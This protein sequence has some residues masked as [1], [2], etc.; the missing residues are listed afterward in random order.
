MTSA[1]FRNR[2][3]ALILGAAA[4]VALLSLAALV[5]LRSTGAPP[6]QADEQSAKGAV[7]PRSA[8]TAEARP[9][10]GAT[11]EAA[12]ASP[13]CASCGTVE[14]VRTLEVRGEPTG[15]QE[16]EQHLSRHVVYRVTVR[17]EDGSYRTLSQ[18]T[19]PAIAVGAKVR[20]LDG[21]VVARQ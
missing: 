11:R 3:H 6:P 17:L 4:I 13:S 5:A 18:P 8:P 19:P 14:A 21:A 20:I 1:M 15:S 12:P 16:L 2:S 9:E 10:R 7:E